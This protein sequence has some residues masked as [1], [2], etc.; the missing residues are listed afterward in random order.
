[1]EAI[2]EIA[3]TTR[4]KINRQLI[5]SAAE[6][7]LTGEITPTKIPVEISIAFVSPQKIKLLNKKWRGIDLPTDV[8]SFLSGDEKQFKIP[9]KFLGELIICPKQVAADARELGR[10]IDF[11][12]AWVVIHG[13][14]HLLGYNHKTK[15]GALTMKQKEDYYLGAIGYLDAKFKNQSAK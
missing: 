6:V 15:K 11:E 5:K 10:T 14:L 7:V 3:N 2:I 1:M 9:F 13:I 4:A 8:L 12:L